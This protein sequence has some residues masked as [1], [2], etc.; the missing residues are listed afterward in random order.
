MKK[1]LLLLLLL[2]VGSLSADPRPVRKNEVSGT[3]HNCRKIRIIASPGN[4]IAEFAAEEAFRL[5]KRAGLD[6]EKEHTSAAK[7]INLVLGKHQDFSDS[8]HSFKNIPDG[9]FRIIKKGNIIC[10]S[11]TDTPERSPFK[12][13]SAMSYGYSKGTL[14]GLY[15]FL[16]RF[17]DIR[18]YFPGK[19]GTLVPRKALALP[20][21]IDILDYPEWEERSYL[22]WTATGGPWYNGVKEYKQNPNP[23]LHNSLRLRANTISTNLSN[24]LHTGRYLE[25]FW[26][27]HPEYF[28]V[29]K[30]GL[31]VPEVRKKDYR[32]QFCLNSRIKEEI[33]QDIKAYF[34]GKPASSRGMKNW[35]NMFSPRGVNL[36]HDDAYLWCQCKVCKKTADAGKIYTD[37]EVRKKVSTDVWKFTCD[38]ARRLKDE[39]VPNARIIMLAYTPYDIVPDCEIPDNVTVVVVVFPGIQGDCNKQQ[40]NDAVINSWRKKCKGPVMLRAWPGKYMNRKFPG[41]PAFHHNLLIDYFTR[42]QGWFCGGFICEGSD[43]QLFRQLNLYLFFKFAWN[44]DADLNKIMDEFFNRMFGKGAP[45]IRKF[46]DELENI[47]DKELIKKSIDDELG[48]NSIVAGYVETWHKIFSSA[49]IRKFDGLFDQAVKAAAGDKESV[50]RIN[51]FRREVYQPLRDKQQAF[52]TTNR[53]RDNW[54]IYPGRTIWLRPRTANTVEVETRI[55]VDETPDTFKVSFFCEEPEMKRITAKV[56]GHDKNAWKDS[57]IEIFFNPSGDRK[58]YLQWCINA[59]GAMDDICSRQGMKFESGAKVSVQRNEKSWQGVLEIPKKSL[60]NYNKNGF[61]VFFGR[62]RILQGTAPRERVYGW[63]VNTDSVPFNEVNMWGTLD[64][65]GKADPNLIKCSDLGGLDSKR[66][67]SPEYT[68]TFRAKESQTIRFDKNVYIS[69]G[70]SLYM[71]TTVPKYMD[72]QFKLKGVLPRTRYRINFFCRTENVKG[73]FSVNVYGAGVKYASQKERRV[74]GTTPWHQRSVIVTTGDKISKIP[75]LAFGC[76]GTTGKIWIDEVRFEPEN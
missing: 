42:R 50:K 65:S 76:N 6:V 63:F 10:I 41:I 30:N 45:F 44:P 13:T 47:W 53:N 61:P 25:R 4:K 29:H 33:Y 20:E 40:R 48:G 70:Q 55:K 66:K 64:L 22:P 31:R 2:T 38:I 9:G 69:G 3:V 52:A 74:S 43:R 1:S 67:N 39:K 72:F 21:K 24:A 15:E 26:K 49:R 68:V 35:G 8:K 75:V 34:E 54:R 56:K 16:E 7:T 14:Y 46:Y 37:P 59:N 23:N 5:L 19:M 71:E 36:T 58:H 51:F 17:A 18:F 73:G 32:T 11:G 60:G 28:A 27:T 12:D 57:D 62:C